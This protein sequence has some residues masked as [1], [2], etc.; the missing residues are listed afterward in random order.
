[1]RAWANDE[2]KLNEFKSKNFFIF[3]MDGT[4]YT[5]DTPLPGAIEL[6][7]RINGSKSR[8]MIYF[9][10]NASR[11]PGYYS[12]KLIKMGFPDPSRQIL[13]SADVLI[14][15]L[16]SHRQNKKIYL[17]GTP[18]LE[19]MFA[20]G[21]VALCQEAPDIVVT[22]FDT[23]L[24]YQKLERACAYIR[25]GAEWLTTHPDINCP[26]ENGY[27]PDCGA[28]NELIR[29]STGKALP[30]AFGKP[31][32]EA[33]DM[34]EEIYSEPRGNMA[35][36]GDRL[37]TDIAMG[38]KNG[39]TAVLVLTGEAGLDDA[40]ALPEELRPDWI[41]ENLDEAGKYI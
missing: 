8:R 22:S 32:P 6:V 21:G 26:V 29:A 40:L 38:K 30:K 5:G 19:G 1:M 31:C 3:D 12:K 7:S 17:V 10:N 36:F 23:T 25:G 33:V 35:I 28:I 13:I 15:F 11:D 27:I 4:V 14:K 34:I 9:T 41:F 24:T 2:K 18:Y 20:R 16:N 39:I 37:Y